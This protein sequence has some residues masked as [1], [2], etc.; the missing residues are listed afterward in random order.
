MIQPSA[1]AA[2]P[3]TADDVRLSK[4]ALTVLEN[5]YLNRDDQGRV[6]ESPAQL[7]RRVAKHVASCEPKWGASAQATQEIEDTFYRQMTERYF[8]PNSPTLMNTGRP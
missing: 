8:M 1:A 6:V 7:F 2:N 4:N 3:V 5:R